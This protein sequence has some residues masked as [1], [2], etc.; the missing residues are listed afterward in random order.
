MPKRKGKVRASKRANEVVANRRASPRVAA[1]AASAPSSSLGDGEEA[2]LGMAVHAPVTAG[3]SS[4]D[5]EGTD[6]GMSSDDGQ[7]A[8][9]VAVRAP[10]KKRRKAMSTQIYEASVEEEQQLV[11]MEGEDEQ[12]VEAR[13][14]VQ[15]EEEEEDD[16]DEDED[17][18]EEEEEEYLGQSDGG[19]D[20][21]QSEDDEFA[22]LPDAEQVVDNGTFSLDRP[23]DGRMG[24]GETWDDFEKEYDED[25][26]E[27]H[28]QH[29]GGASAADAV[30]Q[31]KESFVD[32]SSSS[33]PASASTAAASATISPDGKATRLRN[34]QNTRPELMTI[35]M[36][37][38]HAYKM[39][40]AVLKDHGK[41]R[42]NK[43][44]IAL[45]MSGL[46]KS[47]D[48][49]AKEHG[50]AE[51]SVI[52]RKYTGWK[53]LTE[54]TIHCQRASH[55]KVDQPSPYK[56]VVTEEYKEA[57]LKTVRAERDLTTGEISDVMVD[58]YNLKS[59]ASSVGRALKEMKCRRVR[60]RYRPG[61]S[62]EH[63][64]ARFNFAKK[65]KCTAG[66]TLDSFKQHVWLDYKWF[67]VLNRMRKC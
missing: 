62:T 27:Y 21:L 42:V 54:E 4:D 19:D 60:P 8:P 45:E 2:L 18:D 22:H 41:P 63:L 28:R 36:V 40:K 34:D 48:A 61:L 52:S 33:S 38:Y 1:A 15:A 66:N 11:S 67:Y 29:L 55:T 58:D 16:E 6:D 44:Q 65:W 49:Y 30:A 20:G 9:A 12:M 50:L 35:H 23:C 5:D 64:K 46:G 17:E 7:R 10:R 37:R 57:V 31:D 25:E 53:D 24:T 47:A 26:T 14:L 43:N 13:A 3:A 32:R 39:I 56:T 51:S 59:S